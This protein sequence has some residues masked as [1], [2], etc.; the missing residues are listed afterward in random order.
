[1]P[2]FVASLLVTL[3]VQIQASLIVFTPPILAPDAQQ[4][5]GV[6]AAAVGLVTALIYL[7]SVPSALISGLLVSRIGAIRVS[8]LCVLFASTGIILISTG[9][10]LIIVIGALVVGIGYGAVTPSSSTVLADQAPENVRSL[11]FSIKQSGVPIGGAIA[12]TLVPFL[13]Y[14]FGWRE[15][16][17]ITGLIG[18]FVIVL[19]QLIQKKIDRPTLRSP[20]L[21]QS[22]SL[23]KPI[24]F[25][26]ADRKL[27]ELA[28][29]SFAF[30]G[31]Q[32]SL[33]SYLVVMLT[34]Q[35]QLTVAVAGYALSVAMIAG[36]I[37][38][39]FWGGLADYGISPRRVLGFL[40]FLM[41]LSASAICFVNSEFSITLVYVLAF[42]FGASAVGWNGV[43]IAEVARIAPK[44]QTGMATGGSLAMT[45]SGVVLLPT[46]FW[47]IY[48][49]TN[50]YIWG[51]LALGL[52]TFW[53]GLLFF[54][55]P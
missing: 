8:Q 48:L 1:M 43:Y 10:P 41:G 25:V 2:L 50:S 40:G 15:A 30:S 24:K 35:A 7:A 49:I 53:R 6:S 42:F 52:L 34:E 33:G 54:K 20:E 55:R 4:D 5:I 51:F 3:A 23:I 22:L 21:A 11:I 36:V 18:F 14:R 27:R 45:Y 38:R 12:G 39:L 28:V 26:F 47:L 9:D 16:A 31:M 37:G 29:S 17:I 13:I 19:A 46:S 32:M 44:G